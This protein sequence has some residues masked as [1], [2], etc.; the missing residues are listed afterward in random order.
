VST[1]IFALL[2]S[3][4]PLSKRAAQNKN[5]FGDPWTSKHGK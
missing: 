4:S 5:A 2:D 1:T 3:N